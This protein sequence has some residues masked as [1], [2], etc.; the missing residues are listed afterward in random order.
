MASLAGGLSCK[1]VRF[2]PAIV[3]A[4]LTTCQQRDVPCG[5]VGCGARTP[6]HRTTKNER[7][8]PYTL[9]IG[10]NG[11]LSSLLTAELSWYTW[12]AMHSDVPLG[13]F[14]S[15]VYYRPLSSAASPSLLWRLK[16]SKS[17]LKSCSLGR[18]PQPL[19]PATDAIANQEFG[20]NHSATT[21]PPWRIRRRPV[22]ERN[23]ADINT[24]SKSLLAEMAL[25]NTRHPAL[26]EVLLRPLHR[27]E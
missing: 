2:I 23:S 5:L 6:G 21:M 24:P 20:G 14:W 25:L 22:S 15:S 16:S 4:F 18:V 13:A 27:E 3:A 19:Y 8:V 12:V 9:A 17:A 1:A 7:S 11:G 10:V 26:N